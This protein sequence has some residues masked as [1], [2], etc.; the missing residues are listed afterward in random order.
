MHVEKSWSQ[1]IAPR[2]VQS[3]LSYVKFSA[4]FEFDLQ[5]NTALDFWW[6]DQDTFAFFLF[7]G[8]LWAT[9]VNLICMGSAAWGASH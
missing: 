4:D 6:F 9:H 1:K 8:M 5:K 7:F 3:I 2:I